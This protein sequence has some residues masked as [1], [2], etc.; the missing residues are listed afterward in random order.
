ML[1]AAHHYASEFVDPK[2]VLDNPA[3]DSSEAQRL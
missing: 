1:F 2:F 3:G